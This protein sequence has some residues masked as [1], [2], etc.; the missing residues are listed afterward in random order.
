YPIHYDKG[1]IAPIIKRLVPPEGHPDGTTG[2]RASLGEKET[3]NLPGHTVH[4]VA[5]N[6]FCDFFPFH[7]G[8]GIAQGLFFPGYVLGSDHHLIE[9]AC[10]LVHDNILMTARSGSYMSGPEPYEWKLQGDLVLG[11]D[12]GEGSVKIRNKTLCRA[13]FHNGSP[14]Q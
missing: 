5:R 4:P 8:N 7:F 10:I 11:G 1:F 13:L 9:L 12:K 6:R 3:G 14:G 2:A